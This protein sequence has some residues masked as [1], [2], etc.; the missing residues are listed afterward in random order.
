M[1]WGVDDYVGDIVLTTLCWCVD[2][3]MCCWLVSICWGVRYVHAL[4]RWRVDML[5]TVLVC[6]IMCWWQ[7]LLLV[8]CRGVEELMCWCVDGYVDDLL[9]WWVDV[10]MTVL[11]SLS[12]KM[13]NH[14]GFCPCERSIWVEFFFAHLKKKHV[15]TPDTFRIFE[16]WSLR[17]WNSVS[18]AIFKTH[19]SP[20]LLLFLNNSKFFWEFR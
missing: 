7:S 8:M 20:P 3:L 19:F 6:L 18:I 15:I 13:L 1:C 12:E 10:L 16:P 2:V 5:M 17:S 11:M 9:C 14:I 4:T